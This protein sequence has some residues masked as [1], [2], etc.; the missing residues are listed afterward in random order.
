MRALHAMFAACLMVVGFPAHASNS[1]DVVANDLH[2]LTSGFT[3]SITVSITNTYVAPSVSVMTTN[4]FAV[5]VTNNITVAPAPPSP[6]NHMTI[7]VNANAGDDCPCLFSIFRDIIVALAALA[8]AWFARKGIN[9]YRDEFAVK[10]Q[11]ELAKRLIHAVY[12]VRD[13]FAHV[14]HPFMSV[15]EY[16]KDEQGK[17]LS[18]ATSRKSQYE[19]VS[20]AYEKRWERLVTALRDLE[21]EMT[22]AQ[23]FWGPDKSNMLTPVRQC[24]VSLQIAVENR[25]RSILGEEVYSNSEERTAERQVLYSMG[26]LSKDGFAQKI[27]GALDPIENMVRPHLKPT[28]GS[29]LS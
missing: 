28:R 24:V 10:D 17:L 13:G 25:L 18:D 15:A 29:S 26:D 4:L 11:Y 9:T 27:Q 6:T 1:V 8:A 21:S 12:K 23:V 5:G 20:Y 7:T 14:R 22:Q 3:N 19:S 2:L 16:P